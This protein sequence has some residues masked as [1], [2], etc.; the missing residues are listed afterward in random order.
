MGTLLLALWVSYDL[1]GM[2]RSSI[3][4]EAFRSCEAKA[5]A[6]KSKDEFTSTCLK[7]IQKYLLNLD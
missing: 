5:A 2:K 1:T 3:N 4:L 7:I 6:P